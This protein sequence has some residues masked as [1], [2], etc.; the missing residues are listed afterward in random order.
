MEDQYHTIFEFTSPCGMTAEDAAKCLK[1][2]PSEL[3]AECRFDRRF[4]DN[5]DGSG[6]SESE[7]YESALRKFKEHA[8][9]S[10][11]KMTF[12]MGELLMVSAA[13]KFAGVEDEP[14][15]IVLTCGELMGDR[16]QMIEATPEQLLQ[17]REAL[18]LKVE[19]DD[20]EKAE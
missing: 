8:Q 9:A 19:F 10:D 15:R 4:F 13:A 18:C 11:L 5:F 1:V 14:R 20:E 2:L 16:L 3:P 6:K 17:F 7:V 12:S